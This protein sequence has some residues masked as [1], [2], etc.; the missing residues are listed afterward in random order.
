MIE[1]LRAMRA[2]P[3]PPVVIANHP[4][5][6]APGPGVYGTYSPAELRLWND[7]APEVAVGMAGAPG[8]QAAAMAQKLSDEIVSAIERFFGKSRTAESGRATLPRGLYR[9]SVTLGGF[10]AMTARLGGY[11]DSLL[12][13]G[14]R[15]WITANSDFHVHFTEEDG[16]DFWPGEYSKTYVFAER[17]ADA[18]L[19]RIRAGRMFVTTGDLISELEF[20]VSGEGRTARMGGTLQVAPGTRVRVDIRLRDPATHNANG[21]NPEVTRVDVIVG[22]VAG[23][24]VDRTTDRN[25]TTRVVL[26]LREG[27][28]RRDGEYLAMSLPLVADRD[29]YVRVRGTNT[30]ELEP[31]PDAPGEDPWTDLWFYSNPVFVTVE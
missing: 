19:A 8:H 17:R 18:L 7:T 20:T 10:D 27:D 14:R 26:R 22:D 2:L 28:W 21:Q 3:V 9:G 13:E 24:A 29:Q 23:P 31:E 30:T 4:S 5:R 16:F 25:A 1:A 11:W 12:G 6:S 15:W